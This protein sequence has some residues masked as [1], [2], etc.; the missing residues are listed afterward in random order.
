MKFGCIIG[1]GLAAVATAIGADFLPVTNPK[2]ASPEAHYSLKLNTVVA[3]D[4]RLMGVYLKARI[5]GGPVLR[6]LLD[7]GAQHVILDKRAAARTG[8]TAGAALELV[9]VGAKSKLCK[10]AVAGTVEIGELV[11]DNCDLLVVDGQILEGIDGIIPMS[12]FAGFL[13]RLDVP[14]KVLELDGYP[15]EPAVPG[16]NDLPVRA[17]N[18]L[19][20]LYAA[21]N[22]SLP[23]YVLLDTGATFSAVSAASA[24]AARNYWSQ[25]NAIFL[26]GSSGGIQGFQ[27]SPGVRFRCG[28]HVLSADPAVVVDLSDMARHHQFEITGILG[29]PA[30]RNSTVTINYRDALVRIEGK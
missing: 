11:L 27:L 15:S 14:H 20:F 24:R 1:V 4:M 12:L 26:L 8:Q 17:D 3:P 19:L 22:E 2:V 13:V 30:L 21:M 29:Y 28:T 23:G 16:V 7:S 9:G 25:S 6:M 10:R 5:D 18:H